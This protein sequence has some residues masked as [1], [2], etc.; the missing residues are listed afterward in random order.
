M[1]WLVN[2]WTTCMFN[3]HAV[4]HFLYLHDTQNDLQWICYEVRTIR[5][6]SQGL[7]QTI[8]TRSGAQNQNIMIGLDSTAYSLVDH[9]WEC[10]VLTLPCYHVRILRH[11]AQ[12]LDFSEMLRERTSSAC[13]FWVWCS[14]RWVYKWANWLIITSH[15]FGRLT[16]GSAD[17]DAQRNTAHK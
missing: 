16:W 5:L 12:S 3:V 10:R 4:L 8:Q 9:L 6:L 7:P 1:R 17:A 2:S 14:A 11:C 15:D 13:E